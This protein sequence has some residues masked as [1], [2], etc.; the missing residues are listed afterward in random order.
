MV[1]Q[2]FDPEVLRFFNYL[3]HNPFDLLN[4]WKIHILG[5]DHPGV[6]WAQMSWNSPS[7]E[8]ELP[9]WVTDETLISKYSE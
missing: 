3:R 9:P 1:M 2:F 7:T 6:L 5:Q 4:C 8:T